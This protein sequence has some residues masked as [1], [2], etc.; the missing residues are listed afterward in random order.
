MISFI[1][2]VFQ[3]AR[4]GPLTPRQLASPICRVPTATLDFTQRSPANRLVLRKF[5]IKLESDMLHRCP[6]GTYNEV[7]HSTS[8]SA[9]RV[10]IDAFVIQF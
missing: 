10:T 4:S 3:I 8:L 7:A 6:V 5:F 1:S 9:C 2:V